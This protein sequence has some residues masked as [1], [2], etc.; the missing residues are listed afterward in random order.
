MMET[1]NHGSILEQT[2]GPSVWSVL[3]GICV[4]AGLALAGFLLGIAAGGRAGDT[5]SFWYLSRSAGVVA[6]LLLWGSVAWGVLLSA[7]ARWPFL[8]PAST[9]DAHQFLSNVAL[10]FAFFHAL[11][12][13]GDHYLSIPLGALLTPFASAYE[14]LFVAAGQI[15]LWLSLLL[16]LSY[17]VRHLTGNR[18]WRLFHYTSYGAYWLAFFHSIATGGTSR[19]L[20][21]LVLYLAGGVLIALLTGYRV[22]QSERW[23]RRGV[24]IRSES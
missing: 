21:L 8:R 17:L 15:A 24:E 18:A 1:E 4:T 10:G 6:Y 22:W 12:L 19:S 2:G 11:V 3:L 9:L 5:Q 13:V 7:R 23:T 16:S 14:P 20:P